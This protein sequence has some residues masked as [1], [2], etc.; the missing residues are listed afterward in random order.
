VSHQTRTQFSKPAPAHVTLRVRNHVWNLRSG[1]S[2]RCISTCFAQSRGRFGM[3]L[4]QFT[5]QGNHLH[6]IVE[7]DTKEA[8]SLGMQG[9]AIRIA[10]ALNA[11]MRT[12]GR[13]FADHYHSRLLRSPT[14]LVKA[15]AYFL[16]NHARHFGARGPDRYSSAALEPGER[17]T[18]LAPA[19]SWL[20]RRLPSSATPS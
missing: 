11:M 17:D 15:I 6:L 14:E 4:I 7:A 20:L 10:R 5:I 19:R 2:F 18:L 8:L 16:G 3:R 13:V 9:L 12:A 1:R